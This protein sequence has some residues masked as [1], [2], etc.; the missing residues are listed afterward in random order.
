MKLLIAVVGCEA[1]KEQMAAQRAS[2]AKDFSGIADVR[3]FL[4]RQEREPLADEVFLDVPDDYQALPAKTQAMVRWAVEHDYDRVLKTD[5][6]SVIFPKKFRPPDGEYAGWVIENRPEKTYA[7]GLAYWLSRKPMT[8]VAES[9]Q[10]ADSLAAVRHAEDRWVGAVLREAGVKVV[11][12][13]AIFYVHIQNRPLPETLRQMLPPMYAV[14]E[15][16]AKEIPEIYGY[17]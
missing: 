13:P 10:T 15:F 6:D 9:E 8:I 17:C 5:D 7:S 2:W 12:D 16:Y 1:R 4:A 14:G 3:F 11:N